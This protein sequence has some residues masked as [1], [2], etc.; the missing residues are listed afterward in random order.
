MGET[1]SQTA[2]TQGEWQIT[3]LSNLDLAVLVL[4]GLAVLGVAVWTWRSL[5][6]AISLR[7]RIASVTLRVV[8][9]LICF[10]ILLQPTL[11]RRE[12]KSER[13]RLAILIDS[14]L[15][16][17]QGNR[18]NRLA[19][20]KKMI[21]EAQAELARLA[22][23]YVVDWYEFS[24]TLVPIERPELVGQ[25]K[26]GHLK[27]DI[28][29]ALKTLMGN[30]EKPPVDG[31]LLISDGAD[32][33][34]VPNGE[35]VWTL[36]WAT[37]L[38]VPINTIAVGD[39]PSRVELAITHVE[40]APFAFTRSV[41]PIT[42][43]LRSVG[44][45][46]RQISA[47]LKQDGAVVQRREVQMVGG[48]GQLTFTPLPTTLGQQVMEVSVPVPEGDAVPENNRQHVTF[49]VIRD[50]FRVLHLAGRPSWDQRF[51]R[52]TLKAW[53]K[54]DLVSFYVLRTAYQSASEGSSGMALIP[55]PT[56]DL[57]KDH[58]GEFDVLIF[59][60][61]APAEVGVARY[62]DKIASF[63]QEGGA[64]ILIG[65]DKGLK[66]G[67]FGSSA[68][69]A[70]FPVVL[71]PPGTPASR[72]TDDSQFR[73]KLTEVGAHH[74]LTRLY[75]TAEQ[76]RQV[77]R[78]LSRLDGQG[79]VA[80]LSEG[81]HMLLENPFL[82]ADDGPTPVIAIKEAGKGRT[83]AITTDS[84]WRWRFSGPLNGGAADLYTSFWRKAIA[85]LT[86]APDLKRLRAKVSPSPVVIGNGAEINIELLDESY[87]PI[88]G[89]PIEGR[90]SWIGKDGRG[91]SESFDAKV[92][93]DGKYRKEWTPRCEGA[94]TIEVTSEEGLSNT[95]RFLVVTN[96]QERNHLDVQDSLLKALAEATDGSFGRNRLDTKQINMNTAKGRE[97]VSQ[98]AVSL[99]D[100]PVFIGLLLM[101]IF[102]D[103]FVRRRVGID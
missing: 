98:L 85:W 55:F 103:W 20:V 68:L 43:N 4:L 36:R 35:G 39:A 49:E 52:D 95:Q 21:S 79:R 51:L 62:A 57:F 10:S 86:H 53:P 47:F 66:G 2:G 61:F 16:M 90:I 67:A 78:G 58:L 83:L 45:T 15:S 54:V 82:M 76:N 56:D 44:L 27:T 3:A 12:L 81:A 32:T 37:S 25:T 70:L 1:S 102:A 6:P 72:M 11:H 99:W 97:V 5:D 100:N 101:I 87:R 18:D 40:A 93:S 74:P 17:A 13:A 46:D 59:H 30:P 84:L 75:P 8:G 38:G 88:P 64:L 77:W 69:E 41:T 80:Q 28:R 63:V 48:R 14:S 7:R 26:P 19:R 96:D 94:H 24:D 91:A 34:I 89:M 23:R 65:G 73:A 92:D 22:E 50:K 31:V 60:E 42:V 29:G 9:L 33:E 71:L